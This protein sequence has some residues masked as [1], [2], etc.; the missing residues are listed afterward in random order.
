MSQKSPNV[1]M[2]DSYVP[3]H[4]RLGGGDHEDV[5][6]HVAMREV[7][8]VVPI[9]SES[10]TVMAEKAVVRQVPA[11][12][13]MSKFKHEDFRLDNL[14]AA[15]VRLEEIDFDLCSRAANDELVAKAI[16]LGLLSEEFASVPSFDDVESLKL[17]ENE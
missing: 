13:C 3:R 16:N 7:V 11:H 14:L 17:A 4:I 1:S 5:G 2:R 9:L 10:G 12:E 6:N 15:G 8:E